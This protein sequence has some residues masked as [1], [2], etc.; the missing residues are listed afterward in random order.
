MVLNSNRIIPGSLSLSLGVLTY[1]LIK[2]S[3]EYLGEYPLL[4]LPGQPKPLV[5]FTY[6]GLVLDSICF[7]VYF[8]LRALSQTNPQVLTV[9]WYVVILAVALL[10]APSLPL[11]ALSFLEWSIYGVGSYSIMPLVV[12]II[13]FLW[14]IAFFSRYLLT[15]GPKTSV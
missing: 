12:L 14:P 7:A 6:V 13:V 15:V 2:D 10:T 11:L 5:I 8:G 3:S 1:L 4:P 9:T